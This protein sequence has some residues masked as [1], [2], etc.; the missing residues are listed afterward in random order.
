MKQ[1][2]AVMWRLG[3]EE[4]GEYLHS[5]VEASIMATVVGE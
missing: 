3:E 5:R 2:N 4:Y 1:V